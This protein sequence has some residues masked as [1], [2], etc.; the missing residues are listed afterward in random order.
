M[1]DCAI[2]QGRYTE[3]PR[4]AGISTTAL[5]DRIA[6]RLA[7]DF[8]KH[9]LPSERTPAIVVARELKQGGV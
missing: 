3:V 6:S 5:I 2:A 1:Y 7:V 9:A 4:T 8:E